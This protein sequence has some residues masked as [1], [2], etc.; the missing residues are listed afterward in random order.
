ML[1]DEA[2]QVVAALVAQRVFAHVWRGTAGSN[3]GVRVV[4]ADGR[5]ALWDADGAAGL[6]AQVLRDGVLVGFVPLIA[7]SAEFTLE[8]TVA[9]IAEADYGDG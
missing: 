3:Y 2:E 8:Q 1:A 4:I 9:A 5:E 6:E 7:G